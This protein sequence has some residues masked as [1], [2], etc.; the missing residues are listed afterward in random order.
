MVVEELSAYRRTLSQ[1]YQQMEG[2]EKFNFQETIEE[3]ISFINN[4]V[5]QE[6]QSLLADLADPKDIISSR[7]EEIKDQAS[8][9]ASDIPNQIVSQENHHNQIP[10]ESGAINFSF[11]A[12]NLM[13]RMSSCTSLFP[14]ST[15]DL[16]REIESV[17]DRRKGNLKKYS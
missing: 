3:S 4:L 7:I 2:I 6:L 9:R 14:D 8:L 17:Q 5:D 12:E 11:K 13:S 10:K 16:L 15:H 1:F